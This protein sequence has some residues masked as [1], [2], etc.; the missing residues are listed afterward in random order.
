MSEPFTIRAVPAFSDNYLWL[1]TRG[2]DAA[3]VDPGDAGPV[4]AALRN[5][6]QTL[7]ATDQMTPAPLPSRLLLGAI[8]V[9]H[10]HADHVGGIATLLASAEDLAAAHIP[11]Y[12]PDNEPIPLRTHA[13]HDGDTVTVLDEL[14]EVIAVPG[15]TRGHLAYYAPG[16]QAL[17]C[18]DTLF[19][20]GCG[21]L[22]EGTAAQMQASLARLA[23]LPPA[24]RVYCAHE[25]TLANLHFARAVEPDNPAVQARLL[26]TQAQRARGEPTVPSRIDEELATN[27]FLRVHEASV[28]EAL[29]R[30]LAGGVRPPADGA[31]PVAHFAALRRWKDVF[32][33]QVAPE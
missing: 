17:F 10:H 7:A 32:K 2:K 30:H 5:G 25:Y 1:L 3:V 19:A 20:G 14:M 16:A 28:R 13:L 33:Q 23:A 21:R 27:P 24:T 12:G 8:L 31:D 4:L 11:V 15:H 9:T 26:R 29:H 22:F 6:D 18:G